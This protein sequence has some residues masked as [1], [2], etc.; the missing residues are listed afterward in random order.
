VSLSIKPK[1]LCDSTPD[2]MSPPRST[3]LSFTPA[4]CCTGFSISEG[5]GADVTFSPV[6]ILGTNL[7]RQLVHSVLDISCFMHWNTDCGSSSKQ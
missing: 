4:A 3:S 5:T 7:Q 2:Y 1:R 6:Q